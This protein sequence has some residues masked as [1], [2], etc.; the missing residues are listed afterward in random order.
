M[1]STD[2]AIPVTWPAGVRTGASGRIGRGVCQTHGLSSAFVLVGR[3]T[4]KLFAYTT[5]FRSVVQAIVVGVL[6]AG[7]R[8][9][10]EVGE[11]VAGLRVA[12]GRR[13]RVAGCAKG[14]GVAARQC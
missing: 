9:V 2:A 1:G 11:V 13:D 14:L 12:A 6:G 8:E 4:A 3:P 7:D 10:H 5:L